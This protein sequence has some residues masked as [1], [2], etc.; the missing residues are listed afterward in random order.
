M[1]TAVLPHGKRDSSK[2]ASVVDWK[3]YKSKLREKYVKANETCTDF[4]LNNTIER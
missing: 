2:F 4:K 1:T 3:E